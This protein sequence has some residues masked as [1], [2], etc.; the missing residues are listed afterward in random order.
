MAFWAFLLG[1]F[2]KLGVDDDRRQKASDPE[3]QLLLHLLS[4]FCR[5]QLEKNF[6]I[7]DKNST[8]FL[9]ISR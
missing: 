7:I 1:V 4:C 8:R 9:Q 6:C 2:K 3:F 5:G